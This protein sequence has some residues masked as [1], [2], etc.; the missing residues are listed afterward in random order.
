MAMNPFFRYCARYF[1]KWQFI[2]STWLSG[3]ILDIIEPPGSNCTAMLSAENRNV[4][5]RPEPK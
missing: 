1:W 2:V 4:S 5:S 3:A